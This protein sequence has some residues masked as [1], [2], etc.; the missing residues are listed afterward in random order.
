[1]R[2]S[3]P[4]TSALL[5]LVVLGCGPSATESCQARVDLMCERVF[6]CTLSGEKGTPD[7]Q[8]IYGL[9]VEAC[10]SNFYVANDCDRFD[11]SAELCPVLGQSGTKFNAGRFDDCQRE[12]RNLSCADFRAFRDQPTNPAVA[13]TVCRRICQ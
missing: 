8:S 6:E 7:F 9:D 3:L 1:M 11:E 13:P 10:R 5:S 2:P 12:L 4:I